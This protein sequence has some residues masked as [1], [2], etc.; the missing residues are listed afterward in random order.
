MRFGHPTVL[1]GLLALP[2]F[3]MLYI[4]RAGRRERTVP[5]LT[6]WRAAAA[7]AAAETGR[8]LGSFDLPLLLAL[9]S[10]AGAITAAGEP[11]LL[12]GAGRSPALLVIVDRSASMATRTESGATRWERSVDD[13]AAR[14]DEL[15]GGSVALIGLPLAAG[16]SL[17]EL[18]PSEAVS[19]LRRLA[20][21]DLPLDPARELARCAGLA[22]GASAV[23]VIT[24]NAAVVPETLGGRPVLVVSH[25]G[26]SR[27]V[28][29]DAFEVSGDGDGGRTVFASATTYGGGRADVP[30]ELF[31][32]GR[33]VETGRLSWQGRRAA[34][35]S[36]RPL[37]AAH[38]IELRLN[39]DDDLPADNRAV[40]AV[41]G[42]ET[43]RVA[44]VGRGNPFIV[45]ALELLPGVE[46]SQ[47]RLTGDVAGRFHLYVYDA[48]MPAE[49]PEGDVVLV[50]PP[51]GRTVGPFVVEGEIRAQSPMPAFTTGRSPLLRHVAVD[52]LRFRRVLRVRGRDTPGGAVTRTLITAGEGVVLMR[53]ADERTRATLIGCGLDL[54][55]TNWP[56]RPSFPIFWAHLVAEVAGGRAT[57]AGP[58]YSLT[59]DRVVIRRPPGVT[60]TAA[61]PDGEPVELT[62]RR[63]ARSDFLPARAGVYVVRG[64][65]EPQRYAVNMLHAS[66]SDNAGS[67]TEPPVF[68]E[69]TLAPGG[70][71][72]VPLWR[73]LAIAALA[74]GL[75]HWVAGARRSR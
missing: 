73:H 21:T 50:S 57:S 23:L 63:G 37:G 43:L 51:P 61:G 35:T 2:L 31:A 25:G 3:A 36:S 66:E 75:A 9:L 15:D 48:Q 20:P 22:G 13:A 18:S 39:V 53:S 42:T 59:G 65:A 62:P 16:P 17:R 68:E 72:G 14:L 54:S 11:R 19:E 8:K 24:D 29:I 56:L 40:A 6:L 4:R 69:S 49:L 44:Y 67:A 28:A 74:F 10:L 71:V 30:L 33:L 46:L 47:F 32:D 58:T 64:A 5:S 26:P 34:F 27:N 55:E 7:E 38:E 52:A 41:S 60:L 12:A 1:L 70:G 45:R